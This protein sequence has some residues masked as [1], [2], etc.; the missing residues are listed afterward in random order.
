MKTL[1]LWE[2][3]FR[4]SIPAVAKLIDL[5]ATDGV[6]VGDRH[7]LDAGRSKCVESREWPA[8]RSKG[9]RERL[10]AISEEVAP[11]QDVAR[12]EILVDLRDEAGEIVI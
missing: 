9:K 2:E 11:R 12:I 1:V 7:E 6:G 8:A 5:V 4:E 10:H 3:S